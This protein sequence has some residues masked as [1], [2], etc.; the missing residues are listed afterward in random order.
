MNPSIISLVTDYFKLRW[1][2]AAVYLFGSQATGK[3]HPHSDVDLGIL[4]KRKEEKNADQYMEQYLTELPRR[5]QKDVHPMIM[6]SAG[7]LVAKQIFSKG[8]CILVN[9]PK[10]TAVYRTKM[11]AKIAEFSVLL[12]QIQNKFIRKTLEI[13]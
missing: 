12:E 5:I 13:E 11:Y 7:E 4:L 9:D 10:E 3:A 1:E 6:N 8:R 2:V